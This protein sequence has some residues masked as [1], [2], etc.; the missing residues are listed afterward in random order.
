VASATG[1][2]GYSLA[3]GGP[4]LHPHSEDFLLLP[5]TP[6]LSPAYPL[7]LPAKAI[8]SLRLSTTHQATLGIDGHINMPLTSDAVI[9]VKHSSRVARFLRVHPEAGFYASLEQKL[10]GKK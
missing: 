4:I 10:K 3:A 1:S 8:V 7:V 5:V 9:T 2:T 6:H